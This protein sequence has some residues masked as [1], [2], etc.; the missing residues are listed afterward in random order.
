M[1]LSKTEILLIRACGTHYPLERLESVYRHQYLDCGSEAEREIYL[2][3]I[4][5]D[6]VKKLNIPIDI[7]KLFNDI[8]PSRR[9]MEIHAGNPLDSHWLTVL[10]WCISTIRYLNKSELIEKNGFIA[11]LRH[12]NKNKEVIV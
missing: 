10:K 2:A 7:K 9:M 5:L 8:A 4:M 6:L 12:R 11:P 3:S 1:Q